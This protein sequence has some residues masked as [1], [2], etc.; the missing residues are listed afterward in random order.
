M[1]RS[2]RLRQI[3]TEPITT[4]QYIASSGVPIRD[5]NWLDGGKGIYYHEIN[6]SVEVEVIGNVWENS[7]LVRK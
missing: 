4:N 3:K 2:E 5:W 1:I 7:E 6:K